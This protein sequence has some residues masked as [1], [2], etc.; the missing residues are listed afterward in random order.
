MGL[1]I[2][3]F[4]TV[5]AMFFFVT[6]VAALSLVFKVRQHLQNPFM[7]EGNRPSPPP[8]G[9]GEIIEGEFKVLDEKQK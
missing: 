5:I 2:K 8:P 7:K 3:L 6:I 4:F 1:I 9:K